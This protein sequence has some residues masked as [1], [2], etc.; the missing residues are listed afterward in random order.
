VRSI[1]RLRL[2]DPFDPSRS[3][4][5]D[6][7]HLNIFD[8]QTGAVGLIN[9]SL[10]GPPDDSRS[11]V[12][13]TAVVHVPDVGWLGNVE[14]RGYDEAQIET[15]G[16]GLQRSGFFV[17]ADSGTILTSVRDPR[18][19]VSA[20]I[21]A[22][23][24]APA[25]DLEEHLPLGAGWISWY[26][27]PRLAVAG[28]WVLNGHRFDLSSA[29]AYHDHNWGRW[30]WG[31]DFGWEWGCF[32]SKQNASFVMARTTDRAHKRF[33]T[34]SLIVQVGAERRTFSGG[35][36][37][38]TCTGALDGVA[39][40]LPGAMAALHQGRAYPKLPRYLSIHAY[41]GIDSV[42]LQF[43]GEYAMQLIAGDPIT[44][45]YSFV[46]EIGGTFT[47][48]ASLGGSELAG[49]GLGIFEYVD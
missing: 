11:R 12:L 43:E 47:Y 35:S 9:A 45:G 17:H 49:T 37:R 40:R 13:G 34:P 31:D 42:D 5:K 32:L 2:P 1:D 44:R 41:D 22:K 33:T 28:Y 26:V 16:I 38:I 18:N 6:W 4:Y 8:L 36:I 15:T 46:H 7:L 39:R 25:I 14:I 24:V 20:S 48:K 19:G 30:N 23:P 27:V 21:S 3:R 10:H 29:V